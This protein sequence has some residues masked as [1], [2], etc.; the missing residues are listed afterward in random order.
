VPTHVLLVLMINIGLLVLAYSWIY[1]RYAGNNV[2]RMM[3]ID[4]GLTSLAVLAAGLLFWGRGL[5][6]SL[7][8]LPMN[9][10][11]FSFVTYFVIELPFFLWYVQ[12]HGMWP[13]IQG[14]STVQV[15]RE[16]ADTRWD[17]V[18]TPARQR[19]LAAVTAVGLFA[20]PLLFLFTPFD[21]V[22]LLGV[23]FNGVCLFLLQRSVRLVADAA[24]AAL[25]ERQLAL[26]NRSHHRAYQTLSAL[27]VLAGLALIGWTV[28]QDFAAE[29][30]LQSYVMNVSWDQISALYFTAL[31]VTASLPSLML[32]WDEGNRPQPARA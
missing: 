2:S 23:L 7:I 26:R 22:G 17:V 13:A 9:W 18:R 16:M 28:A 32:A 12:R 1:P 15:Q 8:G 6:F 3:L 20:T 5:E 4:S 27:V 14:Q 21:A 25:D 24:D 29:E 11:F 31:M 19:L 10:F 30:S